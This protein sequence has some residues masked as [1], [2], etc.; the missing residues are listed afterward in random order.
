MKETRIFY[1][2]NLTEETLLPADEAQ[3]AVRVLRLGSGD[4]VMLTDGLGTMA[5]AVITQADKRGCAVSIEQTFS[6]PRLWQGNIHLVVA[7][8]KNSDR[9]EW[10]VEKATEIG[11]DDITFI[12]SENSERRNLRLDRL[13]RN[14]ISA[15]KQSHKA[16]LPRLNGPLPFDEF[17][18]ALPDTP[19]KYICHCYDMEQGKPVETSALASPTRTDKPLLLD[20]LPPQGDAIVLIGPEGDFSLSEVERAIAKGFSSVSLGESRLRTE[21]AALA[22]VHMMYLKKRVAQ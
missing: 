8:T 17:L 22:A 20:V 1:C 14:A 12:I 19:Y 13:N 2:P 6:P 3:H 4:K 9:M 18:N 15:M 5:H 16:W 7:P 21:T 10:F 11:V